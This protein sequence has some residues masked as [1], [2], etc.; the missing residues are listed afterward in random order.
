MMKRTLAQTFVCALRPLV[1]IPV[2]AACAATSMTTTT[3]MTTTTT[4]TN[5][6]SRT[7]TA[8]PAPHRPLCDRE[9]APACGNI[10][11][12]G[13]PSSEST[14]AL[15]PVALGVAVGV[16]VGVVGAV[17]VDAI[18]G[19][20][21]DDDLAALDVPAL[22]LVSV[23]AR[24]S[25]G[26]SPQPSCNEPA[27]LLVAAPQPTPTAPTRPQLDDARRPVCGNIPTKAGTRRECR[28]PVTHERV[29][30]VDEVAAVDVVVQ[31]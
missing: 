10:G 8:P 14:T 6:A 23:A 15:L 27:P 30:E 1:L 21:D 9:G 24:P 11:Q 28:D 13:R 12:T 17:A 5:D 31:P 29:D 22:P 19:A 4:T 25:P 3:L 20:I 16:G 26:S 7:M 2:S 18:V